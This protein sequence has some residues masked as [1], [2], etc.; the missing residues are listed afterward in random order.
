MVPVETELPLRI[1][2]LED[3]F[4]D[5]RLTTLTLRQVAF[6]DKKEY[7]YFKDGSFQGMRT[8][9]KRLPQ[10]LNWVLLFNASL[11]LDA[12]DDQIRAAAVREVRKH[13]EEL[14]KY[15]DVD[16]FKEFG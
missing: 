3:S 4:A 2:H 1:L 14:G 7:G 9:M 8:Y 5:H 6:I 12:T 11:E 15:P 13:V 10:G 16:L